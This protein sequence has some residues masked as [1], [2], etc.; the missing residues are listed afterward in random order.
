M[1]RKS[2]SSLQSVL[3]LLAGV[4]LF[5]AA[6]QPRPVF[7]A[8]NLTVTPITWNV[9]GLDSNNPTTG[10]HVLPEGARLRYWHRYH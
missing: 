5:C 6:F 3:G 10:P 4:A 9:I 1:K 2:G 7:A 8:T